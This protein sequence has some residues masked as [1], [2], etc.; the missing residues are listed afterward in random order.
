MLANHGSSNVITVSSRCFYLRF[1]LTT[2][3]VAHTPQLNSVLL[4][5]D[6]EFINIFDESINEGLQAKFIVLS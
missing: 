5:T 6:K 3:E 2:V 1:S 4:G